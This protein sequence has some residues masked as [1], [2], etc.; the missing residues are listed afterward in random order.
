MSQVLFLLQFR[1][2]SL[3]KTSPQ[4]ALTITSCNFTPLYP[5]PSR[6]LGSF[7]EMGE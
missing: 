2:E 6:Y 5:I 7:K 4:A 1:K 3:P